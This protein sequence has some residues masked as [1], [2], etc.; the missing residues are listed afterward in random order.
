MSK[1]IFVTI[2]MRGGGTERVISVLA[3]RMVAMGYEVSIVMIADSTVEYKLDENIHVISV[4]EATGGSLIG[5]IKRIQNMRK[6]F[7]GD[8]KAKIISMGTV[9]NL[10]TLVASIGLTNPITISERND[11]NRLNHRPIKKYEVWIRNILYRRADRLVLQTPDVVK[12]F[13]KAIQK[14]GVVIGNPL[15]NGLPEPLTVEK[16]D[17]TVVASGRFIP[18]KNYKM[19]IDVFAE[20]SKQYP[21]Y[22]LKIFGKGETEKETRKQIEKL[23][24]RDKIL[25]CGFSSNIYEELG[26]GGM[27]I[28]TSDS[29]GLSN[30]LLEA[31]AMGIPTIATDCP[32]GGTRMCIQDGVNGYMIP[33]RDKEALLDKMIRL[34][35]DVELR[36]M[37][38]E[39]AVRI[40]EE[41]SEVV[42]TEKWL[43]CFD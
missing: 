24:M 9:S 19:L 17:N 5:R 14:K 43:K 22:Q 3:N 20:F 7:S 42:V 30:S 10:F 38:S 28:S 29:E 21:E 39:N 35:E 11:P 13:P 2:S 16:R 41:Y 34:V 31:L 32:V 15:P 4:S 33:V 18:S 26:K 6:E 8:K 40:R 27:Y 12:L 25:L 36:K 37:F 23:G 1:I